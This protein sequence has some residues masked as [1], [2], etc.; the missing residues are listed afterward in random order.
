MSGG[1]GGEA[2]G[3]PALPYPDPAAVRSNP[4]GREPGSSLAAALRQSAL[5]H[6]TRSGSELQATPPHPPHASF[7]TQFGRL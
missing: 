1:V 4:A 2:R 5:R 6:S 7:S 3:E